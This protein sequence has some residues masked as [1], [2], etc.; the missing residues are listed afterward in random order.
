MSV[1][2]VKESLSSCL[3]CYTFSVVD[4]F[5]VVYPNVPQ[6]F[7]MIEQ[8]SNKL[9]KSPLHASPFLSSAKYVLRKQYGRLNL[10]VST[11]E[12]RWIK[13]VP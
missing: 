10:H 12:Q 2:D 8:T 1:I 7:L 6:H 11:T 5:I 13:P 4:I 9:L 3:T